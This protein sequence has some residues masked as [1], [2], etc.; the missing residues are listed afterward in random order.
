MHSVILSKTYN[1]SHFCEKEILR[2]A[3]CKEAN[4]ETEAL[5]KSCI[6]EIK[7]KLIYKV[8]YCQFDVRIC[9]DVCDFG[10]FTLKSKNLASNLKGSESVILFAATVGVEIDRLIAKYGRISPSKALIFQAIGAERIEALCDKFCIDISN[11]YNISTKARFSAGYGDLPLSSQKDIFAVLLPEK[12]IGLTLND[13][14]L[15][16]PSK[17]VTAIVGL[18]GEKKQ[19]NKCYGCN[20]KNCAFRGAL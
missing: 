17:S 19:K 7:N 8:C 18:G 20:M 3:G 6:N 14:L 12:H 16:S 1:E 11:E 9:D 13:S 4:I 2:Y 10:T 5:V 15:M